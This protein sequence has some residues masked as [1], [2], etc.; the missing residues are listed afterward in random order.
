MT[1]QCNVRPSVPLSRFRDPPRSL[2]VVPGRMVPRGSS[3]EIWTATALSIPIQQRRWDLDLHMYHSYCFVFL[4]SLKLCMWFYHWILFTGVKLTNSIWCSARLNK[5]QLFNNR[6][7][8]NIQPVNN[9]LRNITG[10]LLQ[11]QFT[12]PNVNATQT[13]SSDATFGV[14]LANGTINGGK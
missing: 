10:N 13:R 14:K 4:R 7:S 11:C 1:L 12:V 8:P 3:P 2:P 6:D 5:G 9:I